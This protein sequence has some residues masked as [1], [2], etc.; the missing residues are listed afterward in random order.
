MGAPWAGW[1]IYDHFDQYEVQIV[2]TRERLRFPTIYRSKLFLEIKTS[3][4]HFPMNP[5]NTSIA[6]KLQ[7]QGKKVEVSSNAYMHGD[8]QLSEEIREKILESVFSAFGLN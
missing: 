6:V 7:Q 4:L 8:Y 3:L 2:K 1:K 5:L